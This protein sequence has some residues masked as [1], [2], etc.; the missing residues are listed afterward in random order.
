MATDFLGVDIRAKTFPFTQPASFN[1]TRY[2][3]VPWGQ[4][5]INESFDTPAIAAGNNGLISIDIG[6]PAD[7]VA[8]LRNF[9]LAVVDT[10]SVAWNE[11]MLGIAYQQPGGPY[12]ETISS[13]PEQDYSWYQ[14]VGDRV[15]SKDRFTTD[16]YYSTFTFGHRNYENNAFQV[17]AFDDGWSPTQLPIW[18]SPS[19]DSFFNDRTLVM[20]MRN[21]SASQPTQRCTFRASFDLYTFEQAYSAAVMS[22]PRIFS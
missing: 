9:Y 1:A 15:G 13:Y 3:T 10:Q 14:L 2:S 22:S 11:A 16:Q 17:N 18:V 4:A 21:V 8:I 12:K 19:A 20:Y 6:L 5:L 7:Y